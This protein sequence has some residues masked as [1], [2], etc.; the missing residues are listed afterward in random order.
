LSV[1]EFLSGLVIFTEAD[2]GFGCSLGGS[3]VRI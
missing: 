2:D 1:V 3:I